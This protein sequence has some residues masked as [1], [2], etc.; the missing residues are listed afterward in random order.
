MCLSK[1]HVEYLERSNEVDFQQGKISYETYVRFTDIV[2]RCRECELCGNGEY[3][4]IMGECRL[5]FLRVFVSMKRD[6]ERI[7]AEK[8][9][10]G[11]S[12]QMIA[13]AIKGTPV[14]DPPADPATGPAAA[15]EPAPPVAAGAE[16]QSA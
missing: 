15:V 12:A 8:K 3:G 10:S 11:E 5:H 14:S 9:A 13:Q 4:D 2:D 1:K 16:K 7:F 6:T